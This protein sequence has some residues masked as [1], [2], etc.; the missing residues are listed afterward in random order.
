MSRKTRFALD[1]FWD[2]MAFALNSV[3]FLLIG[4]EVS[5]SA[6]LGAWPEILLAF[7]VVVV[8]RAAVV[9]G[10]GALLSRS[11]ERIP[12]NWLSVMTW[13]GLRGA[14]S[15][16]LALALPFDFPNR[17]L[18]ITLTFGVVVLS[19]LVQGLTMQRLLR[20]VGLTQGGARA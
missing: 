2:Y 12:S 18:L 13:G 11:R 5:T 1:A 14:L 6:L 8:A 17:D 19:I 3:V 16:V 4:F 15:M 20:R 7:L 9:Y 10:V